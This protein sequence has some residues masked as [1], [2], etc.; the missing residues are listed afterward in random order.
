ME[1]ER[2]G[3][4]MVFAGIATVFIASLAMVLLGALAPLTS[5]GGVSGGGAFCIVLFFVPICFGA[6]EFPWPLA[7]VT[8]ALALVGL[9]MFIVLLLVS[10]WTL[11][12]AAMKNLTA[13]EDIR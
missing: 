6:G 12:S 8:V 2:L 13:A 4:Y 7:V 3:L 9:A 11:G 5:G 1:L 10:R